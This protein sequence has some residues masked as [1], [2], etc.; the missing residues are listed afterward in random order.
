MA[1]RGAGAAT[2]ADAALRGVLMSLAENDTEGQQWLAIFREGLRDLSWTDGRNLDV[3]YRWAAGNL[4]TARVHAAELTALNPD[5]VFVQHDRPNRAEGE[6][7]YHSYCVRER[8]G[9]GRF[10]FCCELG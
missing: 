2:R 1:A 3:Q 6:N 7:Q 9:S 10:R 4:E 8:N 5:G